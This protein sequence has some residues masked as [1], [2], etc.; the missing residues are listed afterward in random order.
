MRTKKQ[1]IQLFLKITFGILAVG[2]SLLFFFRNSILE[3]ALAR[4]DAKL[5]RDY[6]CE[7]H[8]K[9]A[10]FHGISN[11]EFRDISLVPKKADTLICIK[12]LNTSVNFWHL[13]LGT[14]QLGKLEINQGY[15]QL[16]KNKNGLNFD[17]F[18]KRKK[19][20]KTDD[21][22]VNYAK[23]AYRILSKTLNL[24]PTDM[25]VKG[26]AFRMDDMGNQVIFDFLQLQ[27]ENKKL[28]F[29]IQVKED[30]T[31]QNWSISGFADPRERKANLTFFN[32]QN[33]SIRLPYLAKKIHLKTSFK[34]IHFNLENLDMSGGELH[35][36]GFTSIEDFKI[37]HAKIAKNDVLIKKA[38]FDYRF[39]FGARFMAIDSTSQVKI[40]DIK[41]VPYLSYINDT[42]KIVAFKWN[43]PKMKA[44]N[45]IT[46]LPEGLF[47][48]FK[49]MEAQG[50]FSYRLNFEFNKSKPDQVVFESK[51][52][53]EN[54]KITK[55]GEADL[56]KINSEFTYRAIE[57]G[58][59]QR[60]ILVGQSNVNYTPLDAISP[61]L[62]KCVLTSEDPSFFS[63]RGFIT[64]AFKQSIAKN[65]RTKKFAR[66][67]STISMQLIKNVFLT[68]EK[69]LSR[70]LEEILLVYILENNRIA[71]KERMLEVYFNIIEWGP[72]IY[73][74]GEA[75][76]FYF[77]K[78]PSDLTLKECLFLATIIPR[79]KGFMYRFDAEHRLKSF[80]NQQ[81]DFLTRLLLRRNLITPTDTIGYHLP[82]TI[83]GP[84][85]TFLKS[86]M[87]STP[88]IDSTAVE[89]FGL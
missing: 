64:E 20:E 38:R 59:A 25:N 62:Q 77:Q 24:V 41:C 37:N 69:T 29:L 76:H 50:N 16:V 11:I 61:F 1:K 85:Q 42:D 75:S 13:L 68:R 57:K 53:P 14:V 67:A 83:S 88:N 56:N 3:R 27:L 39:V 18:L 54:L 4:I 21:Q 22:Q 17:A 84:A 28:Q 23:L 26:F 33:D 15:I 72:N 12:Y 60:P 32:T 6:Q 74:I 86:N 89:D 9:S 70:K 44:Q 82:L 78:K 65:I 52:K 79:P 31:K 45:F 55:Y 10:E 46:S 47:S 81:N 87:S 5:T 66:G 40:N 19:E 51:L 73:G 58:I 30:D 8:V 36:D 43:I 34:T 35:I 48:H 49:G 80:A 71:S 7:F 2:L 63:H